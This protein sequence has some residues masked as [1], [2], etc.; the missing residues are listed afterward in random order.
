[1]AWKPPGIDQNPLK[2]QKLGQFGENFTFVRLNVIFSSSIDVLKTPPN[3]TDILPLSY[4]EKDKKAERIV[5]SQLEKL[6]FKFL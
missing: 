3:F 2:S 1:M 5:K 4:Q 6:N